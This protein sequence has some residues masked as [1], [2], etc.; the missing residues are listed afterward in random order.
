MSDTSLWNITK[1]EEY[2]GRTC[3]VLSG[4]TTPSY[5]KK[6]NIDHFTMYVDEAT[7]ILL[8]FEG[9]SSTDQLTQSITTKSISIDAANLSNQINQYVS[10][11]G[12]QTKY[13]SYTETRRTPDVSK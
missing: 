5:G 10:S 1:E 8:K 7:G 12:S 11:Q 2:L 13:K 3:V 4:K 6:L 9:F